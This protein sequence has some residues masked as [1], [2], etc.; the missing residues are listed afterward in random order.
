[1]LLNSTKLRAYRFT[2][3]TTVVTVLLNAANVCKNVF[4]EMPSRYSFERTY[5]QTKKNEHVA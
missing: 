1:M 4:F 3:F 5:I 2:I